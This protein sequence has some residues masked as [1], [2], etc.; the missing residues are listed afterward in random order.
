MSTAPGWA[1]TY[2]DRSLRIV[3][4]FSP[5]GSTDI[6]ARQLAEQ[7]RIG[8]RQPVV[9]ENKPGAGGTIGSDFV[10]KAEPDGYTLLF[11][12]GAHTINPSLYPK[13][14]YDTLKDFAPVAKIAD[15]S[16]MTVVH[17]AVAAKSVGELVALAKANPGRLNFGSAGAGTVT[18]MTGELFKS[19]SGA[20]IQHIPYKGSSQALNDLLGGQVQVM[21]AN[22]P[23]TLQHVQSGRLRAVA[24]NGSTRSSLLPDTP[25]VSES[26]LAG[27]NA[28][29]WYGVFAPAGTPKP[30]IKV[31][32]QEIRRAL[33]SP[34][35]RQT[36]ISEG[37]QPIGGSPE[38]L[39]AFVRNDMAKWADVV[40]RTGAQLK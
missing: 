22:F 16:T 25:T 6:L 8:L 1:D 17:P 31:L 32:N 10:A 40:K 33:E 35:L 26:G 29:T 7:M 4:P 30:I 27:F 18:H 34:E 21:F 3:V 14:T 24:V 15:V 5:G 23:G 13:L 36:I 2:P 9:V 39:G 28:N 20:D 37:G 19:M 12:P 38:E 11:V